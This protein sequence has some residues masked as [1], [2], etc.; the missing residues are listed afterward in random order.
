[1][2]S[3]APVCYWSRVYYWEAAVQI[4]VPTQ[5][6]TQR[7]RLQTPQLR[8]PRLTRALP[9]DLM[10]SRQ[11]SA[12]AAAVNLPD[13]A[14]EVGTDVKTLVKMKPTAP[15]GTRQILWEDLIPQGYEPAGHHAQI[16]GSH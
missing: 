10:P 9:S 4:I 12:M 8:L 3:A 2:S 7:P 13:N 11:Q 5:R 6:P 14:P 1:M 16:S 15:E